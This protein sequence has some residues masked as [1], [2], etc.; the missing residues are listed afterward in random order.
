MTLIEDAL[1]AQLSELSVSYDE[2]SEL[3][4]RLL[5]YGVISRDESNIEAQLYDRY[6]ACSDVVASYFNVLHLRILHDQ[7]FCFVRVF[8]PGSQ[9]PGLPDDDNTLFN[10]GMRYRPS[11][12]E[13]SVILVLRVEYEKALRAGQVNDA[14]CVLVSFENIAFAIKNILKR[15]LPDQASDRK[16]LFQRLKQLRVI[17]F[18]AEEEINMEEGWVSIQPAITSFV[19]DEVL[20]AL[21]SEDE[22]SNRHLGQSS[23]DQNSLEQNKSGDK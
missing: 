5:D 17:Q 21:S 18:S 2:F 1:K 23:S 20:Q 4:I 9:V 3:L 14:G 15:S 22:L 7:Q 8:P 10:Q 6:L 13:V 12:L 16:A 11:Q 19:N